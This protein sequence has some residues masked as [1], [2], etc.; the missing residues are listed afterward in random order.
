MRLTKFSGSDRWR[1]LQRFRG[2]NT[3][4]GC[5]GVDVKRLKII[6]NRPRQD[7]LNT[8]GLTGWNTKI[9]I[10]HCLFHTG[11][12]IFAVKSTD[13]GIEPADCCD[14]TVSRLLAINNSATAKIGTETLGARMG[15]SLSD[16]FAV[17]TAR[18]V[19]LMPTIRR[20]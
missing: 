2:W 18:L 7:C 4:P 8:D 17:H 9:R 13:Y 14:I 5:E 11:D 1:Y 20:R 19:V 16:I 15:N 6:N 3:T 12:D 10:D